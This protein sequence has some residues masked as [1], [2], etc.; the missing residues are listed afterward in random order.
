MVVP[1][2]QEVPQAGP[3]TRPVDVSAAQTT[4]ASRT[5]ALGA[6]W[7]ESCPD[8][9]YANVGESCPLPLSATAVPRESPP[10]L[11]RLWHRE[12]LI[13]SSSRIGQRRSFRPLRGPGGTGADGARMLGLRYRP[14]AQRP[15]V[16]QPTGTPPGHTQPPSGQP[17]GPSVRMRI[18]GSSGSTSP[19]KW[20]GQNARRVRGRG[21][22]TSRPSWIIH[23]PKHSSSSS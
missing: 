12:H 18:P 3:M 20:L 7:G 9:R 5:P 23:R 8:L 16:D 6:W 11:A 17:P 4:S 10:D 13:R 21:I 2:R 22:S 1:V 19:V 14:A 15:E